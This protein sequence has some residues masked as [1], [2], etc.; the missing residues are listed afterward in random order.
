MSGRT[1]CRI[2]GH[3]VAGLVLAAAMVAAF[4]AHGDDGEIEPASIEELAPVRM[5]IERVDLD[6]AREAYAEARKALKGRLREKEVRASMKEVDRQLE[7]LELFKKAEKHAMG[8]DWKKAFGPA[9]KTLRR[10]GDLWFRT[11][12]E[13]LYAGIKQKVCFV[14]NDFETDELRESR[15]GATSEGGTAE[16]V[17]DVRFAADGRHGLRV[18]LDERKKGV[19]AENPA[20]YRSAW[21]RPPAEFAQKLQTHRT[22]VFTIFVHR[23]VKDRISVDIMGNIVDGTAMSSAQYHGIELRRVGRETHR[24][25]LRRFTFHGNF[26]W[27]QAETIQ[28]STTGRE[29]LD[30]TIDDVRL[31]P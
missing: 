2:R 4:P 12:A 7:A 23:P 26:L 3:S 18:K 30:F 17:E 16:V 6:A 22:L 15:F 29:A 8:R 24:L 19:V 10:Y 20:A 11:E 31:V 14:I 28:F 1:A 27:S 25:P 9:S 13:R 21:F 5:S